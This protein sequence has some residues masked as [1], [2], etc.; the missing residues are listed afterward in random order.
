MHS[1]RPTPYRRRD[2]RL[3]GATG[4]ET[5]QLKCDAA[6]SIFRLGPKGVARQRESGSIKIRV[7]CSR[8]E[9]RRARDALTCR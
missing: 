1:H 5:C 7:G 4:P 9:H 3:E 6:V 2:S 8:A